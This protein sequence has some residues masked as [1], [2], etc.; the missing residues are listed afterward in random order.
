MIKDYKATFSLMLVT[1]LVFIFQSVYG[2]LKN[3]NEFFYDYGIT[4]SVI[5]NLEFYKVV[6][7]NFVHFDLTHLFYN[8]LTL[9]FLGLI[10]EKELG[11][12]KFFVTYLTIGILAGLALSLIFLPFNTVAV[13]ASS[14]IFG[15]MGYML[16]NRQLM[17]TQIQIVSIVLFIY[18]IYSIFQTTLGTNIGHVTGFIVGFLLA[19]FSTNIKK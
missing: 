11:S 3:K 5:F 7:F 15:L 12:G 10:L 6:T 18:V 13:G 4:S 2:L 19:K 8:M 1:S 9:L 14:A 17:S 16:C